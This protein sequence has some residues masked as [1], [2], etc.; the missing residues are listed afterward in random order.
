MKGKEEQDLETGAGGMMM[1]AVVVVL[2]LQVITST[3]GSGLGAAASPVRA[4]SV[5]VAHNEG[6]VIL[7]PAGEMENHCTMQ[8]INKAMVRTGA[9]TPYLTLDVDSPAP[10]SAPQGAALTCGSI[11]TCTCVKVR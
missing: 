7:I 3:L 1:T 4:M 8:I 11:S 9:T 5:S 6:I 10:L 2:L